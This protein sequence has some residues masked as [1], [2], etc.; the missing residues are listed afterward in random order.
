MLGLRVTNLL[1]VPTPKECESEFCSLDLKQIEKLFSVVLYL[2][3]LLYG[4]NQEIILTK[5]KFFPNIHH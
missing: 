1:C 5:N 4:H 2:A 3:L